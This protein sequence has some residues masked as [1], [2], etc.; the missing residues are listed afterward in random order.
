MYAHTF[1]QYTYGI[2][3]AIVYTCL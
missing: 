3:V 2:H 1:M